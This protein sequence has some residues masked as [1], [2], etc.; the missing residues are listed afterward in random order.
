MVKGNKDASKYEYWIDM[1]HPWDW[2]LIVS[3]EYSSDFEMGE[4]WG[5]NRFY[6]IDALIEEGFLFEED[7]SL[8]LKFYVWASSYP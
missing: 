7:T 6:W 2:D 4:C 8:H 3:W 1:I 5:Y